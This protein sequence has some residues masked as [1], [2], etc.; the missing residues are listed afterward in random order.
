MT[1][2]DTEPPWWSAS[3]AWRLLRCRASATSASIPTKPPERAPDNSG[4]T[5]H[6]ALQAWVEAREWNLAD[7]GTRLQERFDEVAVAHKLDTP[8]MPQAVVTRAR[9][10]SRGREL[11]ELLTQASGEMHSELLL[12][13]NDQRLFGILDIAT[14]GPGGI[15]IDLK[16]GGDASA[17]SS[18]AIEH[19]MTFYT[20]LFRVAYGTLPERVIVFSLTRG[21]TE[22][23]IAPSA[24]SALLER[25]RDARLEDITT[26][27]P[28]SEVCRFCPKRMVCQPHWDAVSAWD[29]ADAIE[30]VISR[31]EVSSS[32]TAA[33]LIGSQ[34]LT[35]IPVNLIPEAAAPGQFARAV[36]IRRRGDRE[37]EEWSASSNTSL[38]I[39]VA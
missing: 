33:L 16:T 23:R 8:R 7:P 20:H 19:Q 13:D 34:L 25:I 10:K 30:G 38:L 32:G 11:A 6:L 14:S 15:I 1:R 29:H 21:P 24:I 26:T 28:D 4:A 2:A 37:A 12:R 9:L 27:R 5:A 36:R 3:A 35:G 22:M 31:I 17:P 39:Q 18:S